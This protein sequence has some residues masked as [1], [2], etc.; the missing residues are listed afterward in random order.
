[1]K[2]EDT[3]TR[4]REC[5]LRFCH[6]EAAR[7]ALVRLQRRCGSEHSPQEFLA[8]VAEAYMSLKPPPTAESA[9]Y[10][11]QVFVRA[12]DYVHQQRPTP[13]IAVLGCDGTTLAGR[14]YAY[15]M[16]SV[17]EVFA[18][19]DSA[20]ACNVTNANDFTLEPVDVLVMHSVAHFVPFLPDFLTK[21]AAI[22]R[23][24][25]YLVLAHEPNARFWQNHACMTAMRGRMQPTG[26]KAWKQWIKG[27]LRVGRT[28]PFERDVN[29]ILRESAGT[30]GRMALMEINRLVDP[31][32]RGLKPPLL[33]IGLDG[34][35]PS[36][37]GAFLPDFRLMWEESYG[38][39]GFDGAD[40]TAAIWRER[41]AALKE[42]Y[43]LDGAN[44]SSVWK[45]VDG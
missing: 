32:R 40:V 21:V 5:P 16:H 36:T 34:L 26:R 37:L 35:D 30:T 15:A 22:V 31:H 13:E 29:R 9:R 19:A 17:Q 42:K 43:P 27:W 24:Q 6:H 44:F 45:K 4:D 11:H 3:A 12:L 1:M 39:V 38:H 25:G 14:S 2:L 41:N 33:D 10:S 7:Q 20:V 8:L 18:E 28:D 23:P